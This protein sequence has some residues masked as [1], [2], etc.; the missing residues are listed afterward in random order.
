MKI[1]HIVN[2]LEIQLKHESSYLHIAQP[3]TLKSMLDSKLQSKNPENIDLFATKHKDENVECPEGF[4]MAPDLT[5][6]SYDV[7]PELPKTRALPLI[8]DIFHALYQSSEADYFIYTNIDIGLFPDFYDRVFD[9]IEKR[10]LDFFTIDR[11]VMPQFINNEL[12]DQH[13]FQKLFTVDGK[14]HTGID[15][16]VFKRDLLKKANFRHVFIGCFPVGRVIRAEFIQHC[17]SRRKNRSRKKTGRIRSGARLTFHIGEDKSWIHR[18]AFN[19][20]N[21]KEAIRCGHEKVIQPESLREELKLNIKNN[22]Q[23]RT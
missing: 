3:V 20:A 16:F 19:I 23:S 11:E 12:I 9:I 15:C 7:F 5:R 17:R 18:D 10:D 4:L 8:S 22:D 21:Y 1:A 13:N 2:I 6:Y 14:S